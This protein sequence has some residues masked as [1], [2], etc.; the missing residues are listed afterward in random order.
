MAYQDLLYSLEGQT[1]V[2]TLNRH[3]KRNALSLNLMLELI[4]CFDAIGHD[5]QVRAVVLAAAGK[6][7][8]SGH[9]LGEL[10]GRGVNEYRRIFDVCTE[11]MTKIQSISTTATSGCSSKSSPARRRLAPH[12][13]VLLRC[14][15]DRPRRL[16]RQVL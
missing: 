13:P 1:A 2:V 8:C 12:R 5:P 7:F 3:E 14:R 4:G 11:L 6:V 9:D 10:R 16:Q 15:P